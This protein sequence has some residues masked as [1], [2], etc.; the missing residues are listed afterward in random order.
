MIVALKYGANFCS[1]LLKKIIQNFIYCKHCTFK[2][3]PD[4]CFLKNI[5]TI[6][7][8]QSLRRSSWDTLMHA[9]DELISFSMALVTSDKV[10]ILRMAF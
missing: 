5:K 8:H 9:H 6:E 7:M 3:L 2:D 4:M 1:D 10:I